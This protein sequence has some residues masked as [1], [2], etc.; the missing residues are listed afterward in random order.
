MFLLGMQKTFGTDGFDIIE[1]PEATPVSIENFSELQDL[2]PAIS[3][4][5]RIDCL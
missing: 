1:L 4:P 2:F 3:E 5:M